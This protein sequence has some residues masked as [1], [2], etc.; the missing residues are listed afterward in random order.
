MTNIRKTVED[1][2]PH[3]LN[4]V[5]EFEGSMQLTPE[6][7]AIIGFQGDLTV[8]AVAGS[9]KTSTIIAYASGLPEKAKIL[10]LAFNRS[11][12]LEATERFRRKGII[13]A[14]VETAHSLAFKRIVRKY[15][16]K[17]KADGYKPHELVDLLG[18]KNSGELLSEYIL[19]NHVLNLATLFCN[20]SFEKVAQCDYAAT[21][22][23]ARPKA[24]YKKHTSAVVR[25]TR[26]FL[27]M[28]DRGD[29]PITHDYYLKKFQLSKP[30]LDYT[31]IFFDEGQDASPAMLDVFLNQRGTKIVVGDTHQQIYSWRYAVNSLEQTPFEEKA[32]STSFRFDQTIADLANHV[33]T[34][35]DLFK[36]E[37]KFRVKGVASWPD[38]S[39]QTKATIARSNL[40][41]LL[42]AIEFISDHPRSPLYFEGSIHSYT[43][44][45]EGASLYDV[46]NLYN[47]RRS[48]I[49]DPLIKKMRDLEELEEFIDKT[50]DVQLSMMLEV[51]TEYGNR[52]PGLIKKLKDNHVDAKDKEKADMIFSTVHRSK[53][54]EYDSVW[55]VND[56]RNRSDL[57]KIIAESEEVDETRLIEEINLAYVAITRAKKQLHIHQRMLPE[58]YKAPQHIK[59]YGGRPEPESRSARS[60]SA[61]N[62]EKP[63]QGS[64]EWLEKKREKN[65][66]AYKPWTENEDFELTEMYCNREKVKEI[67]FKLGRSRGA[68]RSRIKKLELEEKYGD[69]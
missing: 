35:K 32:L 51:V 52:I 33:L 1:G 40:G 46:L 13:N 7:K 22:S 56:F 59:V 17:V 47:D 69:Q 2:S 16:Y 18:I 38:D 3:L 34:W 68:I 8:N 36:K 39:I 21:L 43:Y 44:A 45:D 24:F 64:S 10:Y 62:D 41:L 60:S 54:M 53:G 15:G 58:E 61:P 66:A 57:E 20:S 28:M 23:E 48:R 6:Q 25:H 37:S 12:R 14:H 4:L 65:K 31:H 67:A 30:Q 5:I 50:G 49:R 9:G 26:Q 63:R 42:K 19:A 55:M 11:V 29:V 27:G